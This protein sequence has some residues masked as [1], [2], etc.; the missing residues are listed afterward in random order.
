MPAD[1]IWNPWMTAEADPDRTA[2][3]ADD[4]SCTFGELTATADRLQRG[5]AAAG[6]VDGMV[7]A[8]GLSTGPQLFALVLAA[9][10]GGYGLFPVAAEMDAESRL[11]LLRSAGARLDVLAGAAQLTSPV[12]T[13]T[14]DTLLD[15]GDRVSPAGDF[16][17]AG[18][19][20]FATSGTTGE[21]NVVIRRRPWYPYRG[22]AVLEGLAAGLSKGPHIMANPTFH[23]GTLAPAL[24][25]LQAG[26]TVVV[27][28]HWSADQFNDAVDTHRADSAFLSPDQL[29]DI[30]ASQRPPAH[31]LRRLFH[32]GSPT[33][34]AVKRAVMERYGPV[35]HEYYGTSI[36][37]IS[38][39]SAEE[40]QLR[41]G[42]AGRPLR[43][44]RVTIVR[45]GA[46]AA[47]GEI[48]A[49]HVG[50]RAVDLGGDPR[51]LT[52]TGDIGF[53]DD[54]GYL[55]VVGRGT[56]DEDGPALLEHRVRAMPEVTDAVVAV[57]GESI[58]CLVEGSLD[59]AFADRVRSLAEDMGLA[60]V[61]VVTVGSGTLPRTDTGKIRRAALPAALSAPLPPRPKGSHADR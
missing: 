11:R 26:S 43:G 52:D 17:R 27:M 58:R 5:L 12:T 38:E 18:F 47:A 9:L 49:I 34:P 37:T 45:N 50:Y 61:E 51:S 59:D 55:Y 24:Y 32:G 25:A 1:Y 8:T 40:W 48:G 15:L 28:S 16:P 30:A 33:A 2:V 53:L 54:D 41:P 3:I 21:K 56:G 14:V 23:F 35:L 6:A 7:A 60:D 39:V 20:V 36:G 46:P 42:T 44:V 13:I 31:R 57:G 22:V 19:L 29:A 4:G 10:R